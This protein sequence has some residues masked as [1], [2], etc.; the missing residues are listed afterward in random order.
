MR[1][2]SFVAIVL[3]SGCHPAG[4]AR[5]ATPVTGDERSPIDNLFVKHEQSTSFANQTRLSCLSG[6]AEA[7]ATQV[8]KKTTKPHVKAWYCV[9]L[10]D[11]VGVLETPTVSV[12]QAGP[13]CIEFARHTTQ[14]TPPSTRTPYSGE[15]FLNVSQMADALKGCRGKL[16]QAPK[17]QSLEELQ[18]ETFCSCV[19]DSMRARRTTSTNVPVAET[20]ICANAAGFAW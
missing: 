20:R 17:T 1:R 13:S 7:E 2:L 16:E 15:S 3:L 9:C 8:P 11:A 5:S 4:G 12:E 14:K 19:V 6:L 10:A 18:K